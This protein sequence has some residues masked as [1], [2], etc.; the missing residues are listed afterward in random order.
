MYTMYLSL[1]V[2]LD[3]AVGRS[4]WDIYMLAAVNAAE[5]FHNRP[6]DFVTSQML[7]L[8]NEVL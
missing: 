8:I 5:T 1:I 4:G 3:L 7:N 6:E 2:L